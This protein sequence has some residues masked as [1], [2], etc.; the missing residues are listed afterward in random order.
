M[1]FLRLARSLLL[2]S[3]AA[4]PASALTVEDAIIYVLETNPD[5]QAAEANKQAIEFELDRA[6]AFRTPKFRLEGWAGSS[7]DFGSNSAGPGSPVEGYE[8]SAIVS[9]RIFDGFFTRSEIERQAYRI[10]AAA[11]RV[12]ERSEFLA[13]EAVRL[14]ADVL[15]MQ[16]LLGLARSN[17]A[18]HREVVSRI[19]GAFDTGVVGPGDLIQAEERLLVAE[20]VL[21]EFELDYDDTRAFFLE[22]VGV[23]AESLGSVPS[24]ASRMPSSLD[25]A[26]STARRT[27]P[28]IRFMQADVGSAESLSRRVAHNRFPTVDLE[29]EGR[30][31]EDVEGLEGTVNDVSVG[32]K[33]RYE[34]Q[35]RANK[36]NRQE[37]VRRV[38]E[39][40][41]RLLSQTRLVEREMR[42]SWSNME[43]ARE[44]V[45]LLSEQVAEL[46]ELRA[47]Y[48]TEFQVGTRSLLDVL[49]T[50]NALF[51]AEASLVNTRV[52]DT[53]VKYRVL[54][55]SGVLLR[56]LGIEPPE[57]SEIYA[58][59]KVGAPPVNAAETGARFD[60]RDFRS[61]RKSLDN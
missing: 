36:A 61:W 38:N 42:Q 35:G 3:A 7:R 43:T 23:E 14:Y 28:T 47:T 8:V 44:R 56:S 59:E 40:R 39:S 58:R 52:L 50:Q 26:L 21:L 29:V 1:Q 10:D 60:A 49:N 51:R 24:V 13:L 20:D 11:L 15:R 2:C 46:R 9:Q 5:I 4:L 34:F 31:G 18:Y 17:V 55:A 57:D 22:V 33:F 6:Q 41:A 19:Q 27:N 37:H 25:A 48:E 54:A 30:Y 12:L 45:G 32:L 53:Y 16:Q